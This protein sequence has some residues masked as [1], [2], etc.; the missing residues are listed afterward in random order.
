MIKK[1]YL[2]LKVREQEKEGTFV[3]MRAYKPFWRSRIGSV[4]QWGPRRGYHHADAVFICGRKAWRAA[5]LGIELARTPKD[6]KD[7]VGS[8]V[9]Y[10]IECKFY[11]DELGWL[12]V[13]F[14]IV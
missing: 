8:E 1:K 7:V 10:E 11:A 13:K 5:V 9:C 12:K 4:Y 6:L 2:E 14:P 3:E